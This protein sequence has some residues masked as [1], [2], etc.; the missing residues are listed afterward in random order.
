MENL[1][2]EK[3]KTKIDEFVHLVY[4][5]SKKFPKDEIYGVTSQL[6]RAALSIALNY[7]EGYARNRHLVLI[8]FLEISYGSLQECKYLIGFCFKEKYLEK[9]ELDKSLSL[10]EEIGAMLWTTIKNLKNKNPDT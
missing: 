9:E 10:A 1:F 3:L 8:N 4:K 5:F 6:R 7:T 2:H